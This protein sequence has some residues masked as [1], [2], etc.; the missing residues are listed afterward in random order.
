IE[1][2]EPSPVESV[3]EALVLGIRDYVKKCG[4]RS[5]VMGLSGGIDSAVTCCLA[6]AALGKDNVLGVTMPSQFSSQGSVADSCRLAHNLGIEILTIPISEVYHKYLETLQAVFQGREMDITEENIQARIRGNILMAISNK[7]GHLVLNTGNKSELAVGYCTLYG[8]MTGGLSVLSDVPK[9]MVYEL[10]TFINRQ[11]EVIPRATI[12]KPPSA[13]LKPNQK[14]QDVLP[15]YD[16]LDHIIR[17]YVDE[18]AAP[19][20][21]VAE[22]LDRDIVLRT[23]KQIDRSEFKRRQAAPG[24]KVTSKAFGM[25]RR[26]PVAARYEHTP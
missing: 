19:E 9:T 17:R 25:G 8:D 3:Y 16:V 6:V 14:D 13:E 24:I 7:F 18:G 20:A 11:G 23:V 10:A 4:F 21:I 5:V 12:E 26:F 1:F 22:G 15:P 2:Q